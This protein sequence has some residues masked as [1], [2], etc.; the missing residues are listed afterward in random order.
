MTDRRWAA[1][2][3]VWT[4]SLG[5][6]LHFTYDWSGD[7]LLVG[8]F[9]AVNESTWEHLK[10]LVVPAMIWAAFRYRLRPREW[11]RASA[12]DGVALLSGLL[13][14][15]GGFNLYRSVLPDEFV[16]DIL[17]FVLAAACTHFAPALANRLVPRDLAWRSGIALLMG[18]VLVAFALF[19]VMPPHL[20]IFRDPNSRGYGLG[21]ARTNS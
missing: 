21:A 20:P 6:A 8:L 18:A 10:L 15:V 9:S 17:L 1:L 5:S 4:I 19:T 7:S 2:G 12:S 16:L 14:I 13:L 11:F 3:F